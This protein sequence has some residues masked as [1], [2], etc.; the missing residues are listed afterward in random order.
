[1]ENYAFVNTLHLLPDI[2]LKHHGI[3]GPYFVAASSGKS[4][5][6][7]FDRNP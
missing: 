6:S 3:A 4:I 1:M 5:H 2:F 7:M